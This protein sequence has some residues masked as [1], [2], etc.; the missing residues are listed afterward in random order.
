MSETTSKRAIADCPDCGEK[1][2]IRGPVV[3]GRQIV[4]PHCD[5]ELEIVETDPIELD[6]AYEE[7]DEEEE[8]EDW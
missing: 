3:L 6:W 8:D 5:A 1:I 7:Y 2:T 4:C